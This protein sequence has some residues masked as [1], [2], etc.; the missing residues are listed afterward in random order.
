MH[1]ENE[2]KVQLES[3]KEDIHTVSESLEPL[4]SALYHCTNESFV[5][6]M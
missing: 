4:V 5:L 6:T 3:L 1:F 2:D